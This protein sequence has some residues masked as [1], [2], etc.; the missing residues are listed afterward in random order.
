MTQVD[1]TLTGPLT[2]RALS[3]IEQEEIQRRTVRSLLVSQVW[4]G[5]A[6][7]SGYSVV[8]LL[9]DDIT[10]NETLAGLSAACLSIGAALASFPLARLMAR[11]GRRPGL[12]TGYLIGAVGA[13]LAVLAAITRFFPLLPLGVMGIGAGSAANL[14]ARYAAAD[15][16]R[17]EKRGQ[18]I[19]T[20]VWATTLGSATGSLISL[21]VFDPAGQ[22]LGL[23]DFGGSFL[24]GSLL[25]L[26]AAAL[27]EWRLRPDPLVVAGGIGRTVDEGRLPFRAAMGLILASPRARLAVLGMMIS[28]GTMVGVMTL[29]PLHMRDGGQTKNQISVMLFLHILGMY[30]FS[31]LVGR[32]TDRI[33]RYPM[34][35]AAGVLC[36]GGALTA[37]YSPDG[38]FPGIALA[39]F[40]I[41]IAW[42]FGIVAASGLLTESF[43]IAQ[44]ASVQG[45]G[46]LCMAGFGASS[47]VAAGAIVAAR[48]Y[49]DLSM[50]AATLGVVL[51]AAVFATLATDRGRP[52]KL[53]PAAG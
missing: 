42:S 38:S 18:A 14:A 19:G 33:G 43:P 24:T 30:A 25:F 47:G 10:D 53:A 15:L 39:L 5:M 49:H 16:A 40:L 34:I 17:P 28:Q 35:V 32:M 27:V 22:R 1:D 9:A 46:D 20:I 26:G 36:A 50:A 11:S 23:P 12:R 3:E 45:A 44:R 21:M 52:A 51:V 37:A 2:H 41:G 31:P 29:T 13:F 8:A 7:V 6:L 48:S 4:G